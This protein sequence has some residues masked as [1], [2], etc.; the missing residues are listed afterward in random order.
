MKSAQLFGVVFAL[1]QSM[2]FFAYAAIFYFGAW[3]IA[4]DGLP[5]DAMFK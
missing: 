1:L 5:Y 3:L 2:I 4:H